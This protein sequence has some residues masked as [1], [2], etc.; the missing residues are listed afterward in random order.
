MFGDYQSRF[1]RYIEEYYD[2]K[3]KVVL[4]KIQMIDVNGR[5]CELEI[6]KRDD[7]IEINLDDCHDN[8]A[9]VFQNQ[10]DV[11]LAI[12]ELSKLRKELYGENYTEI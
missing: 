3:R 1:F 11:D 7:K 2:S 12:Y 10:A 4:M 9:G 6:V 8:V 5:N